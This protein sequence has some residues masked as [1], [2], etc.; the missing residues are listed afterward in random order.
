[1]TRL[2]GRGRNQ[3][4][5]SVVKRPAHGGRRSERLNY[6]DSR[7]KTAGSGRLGELRSAALLR[8]AQTAEF[9]DARKFRRAKRHHGEAALAHEGDF[10]QRGFGF[11]L[12]ERDR[13]RQRFHRL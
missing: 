1:S 12:S 2:P 6:R 8:L 9:L 4:R 3:S 10:L 7:N 13:L 5:E 11:D